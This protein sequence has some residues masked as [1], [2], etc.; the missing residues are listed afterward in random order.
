M[1]DAFARTLIDA[2]QPHDAAHPEAPGLYAIFL[3]PRC[4]LLPICPGG[5]GLLYLGT[6]DEGLCAREHF[7][8]SS[9]ASGLRRTLG[10][11]LRKHLWLQPCPRAPGPGDAHARN[12]AFAVDGE[13]ILSRWMRANLLVSAL[14]AP[15]A[16]RGKLE[17]DLIALLTPPLNLAGWDNPNRPLIKRMRADCTRL[18]RE[19]ARAAA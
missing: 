8:A 9:S 3:R 1:I 17:A 19:L 10:A 2:R 15:N 14:P 6:T 13:A 18:A 16:D 4:Q 12:Y 5:H 11:I 7:T